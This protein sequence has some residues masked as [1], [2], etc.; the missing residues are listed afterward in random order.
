MTSN[1]HHWLKE[2]LTAIVAVQKCTFNRADN[3]TGTGGTKA[4]LN[5]H[6]WTGA[7]IGVYCIDA[8][9]KPR[10]LKAMLQSEATHGAGTLFLIAA[11]LIP[12]DKHISTLPDWL[13][14]LHRLTN[15]RIYSYAHQAGDHSLREVHFESTGIVS[16]YKTVYGPAVRFGGFRYSR[17]TVNHNPL[18]GLWILADFGAKAFWKA[19]SDGRRTSPP[20]RYHW[21]QHNAETPF[22][23]PTDDLSESYRLLGIKPEAT[24]EE[25]KSAFRQLALSLHPDTS[26]LEVQ[27][28]EARF[29]ALTA[30]YTLIKTVNNW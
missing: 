14:A 5:I 21:H 24:R 8:P 28:A 13:E 22:A 25:A 20:P 26:T 7:R 2:Q 9:T 15:E 6:L 19:P 18:K 1:F 29:K 17:Q 3:F 30:A 27:E 12:P 16:E 23:P 11:H 4:D 10:Q